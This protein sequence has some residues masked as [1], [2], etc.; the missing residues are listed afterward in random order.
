MKGIKLSSI[1]SKGMVLQR[2]DK[3]KVYGKAENNIKIEV[4][5][6]NKKYETTSDNKGNWSVLLCNLEAGGPYT[7]TIKAKEK[8]IIDDILIGDV[9]LCSGQSNMELPIERVMDLYEDELAECSNNNI[10]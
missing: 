7:M 8:L 9:W 3:T 10:R 4:E 5:F 2:G 6:L 1:L